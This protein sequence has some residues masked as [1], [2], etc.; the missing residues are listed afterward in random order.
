MT[1]TRTRRSTRTATN[2]AERAKRDTARETRLVELHEQITTGVQAL[3]DSTGWRAMLDTAAKFHRYSLGNQLLVA[4]QRPDATRVAGFTIWQALGRVVR[5]GERGIAIL[6]PCPSYTPAGDPDAAATEDTG[7][8]DT[9]EGGGEDPQTGRRAGRARSR[10]AHV[11]DIAQTEG[12]PLPEVA[13]LLLDGDAPAGLGGALAAQVH[14]HGF[15]VQRG[16][17]GQANGYT[18]PATRVVRVRTD[19]TDAQAAKTL[20]HE[21]AHIVCGHTTDLPTYLTCRGRCEVE[22]E[23]VAYSWPGPRAWTPATTP[24]ATS[25][26]GPTGTPTRSA[27]AP[28]P[29]WVPPAPSSTSSPPP[30]ATRATTPKP[31]T[32]RAPSRPPGAGCPTAHHGVGGVR[33]RHHTTRETP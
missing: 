32:S 7:E 21:L 11:F 26:D 16:V 8:Q 17:C 12:E 13:P 28:R 9:T 31:S 3:A 1:T 20:A 30:T 25:P 5:K 14:A 33:H 19:V 15:Q 6:A 2:P 23:S 4:A 27:T 18:D 22:A 29:S 10:V 24:S